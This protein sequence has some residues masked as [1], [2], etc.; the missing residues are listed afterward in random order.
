VTWFELDE[1]VHVAGGREIVAKRGPEKR[2]SEDVMAAAE[3][4]QRFT[5]DVDPRAHDRILPHEPAQRPGVTA[6]AAAASSPLVARRRQPGAAVHLRC[7]AVRRAGARHRGPGTSARSPSSDAV[8]EPPRSRR[9][10]LDPATGL[11]LARAGRGRPRPGRRMRG[12]T[13]RASYSA[14]GCSLEEAPRPCSPPS[15]ACPAGCLDWL[16]L[17]TMPP[18]AYS[19]RGSRRARPWR[20]LRGGE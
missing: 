11:F 6:G 3:G 1:H 19:P 8:G 9:L 7:C 14:C 20:A 17:A 2:Q 10:L 5:V 16:R 13:T 15:F 12:G 18:G 4:R